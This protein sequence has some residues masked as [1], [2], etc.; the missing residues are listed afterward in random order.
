LKEGLF[1][2]AS[3]EFSQKHG[4]FLSLGL[5][6]VAFVF[7]IFALVLLLGAGQEGSPFSILIILSGLL[8]VLNS[9]GAFIF[10]S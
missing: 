9:I 6:I 3:F 8:I 5:G 7:S 2:R 4:F 10:D 1:E